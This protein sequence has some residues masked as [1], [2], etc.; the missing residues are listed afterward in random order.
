MAPTPN[1][2]RTIPVFHLYEFNDRDFY[3][4]F[5]TETK[6]IDGVARLVYS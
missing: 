5:S 1:T 6:A 4:T 2:T 3:R